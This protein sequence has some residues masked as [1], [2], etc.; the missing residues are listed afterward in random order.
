VYIGEVNLISDNINEI[1]MWKIAERL[2]KT[3]RGRQYG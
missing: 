2:E 3:L 1:N